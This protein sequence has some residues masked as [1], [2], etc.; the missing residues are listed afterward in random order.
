MDKSWFFRGLHFEP[1]Q[2]NVL[3]VTEESLIHGTAGGDRKPPIVVIQEKIAEDIGVKLA[4]RW[5]EIITIPPPVIAVNFDEPQQT[6]ESIAFRPKITKTRRV[7]SERG[8]QK[9]KA[10]GIVINTLEK[11]LLC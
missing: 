7:K 8:Q 4:E 2:G 1:R 11:R 9:S 3:G 5:S 6:S 10:I